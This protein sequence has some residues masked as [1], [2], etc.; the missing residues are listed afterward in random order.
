MNQ[1]AKQ[2]GSECCLLRSIRH[3]ESE[4]VHNRLIL[5]DPNQAAELIST[6]HEDDP[7]THVNNFAGSYQALT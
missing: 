2:Q 1:N 4:S 3:I 7:D 5:P 6:S